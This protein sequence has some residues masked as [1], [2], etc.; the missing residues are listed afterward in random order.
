MDTL[1]SGCGGKKGGCNLPADRLMNIYRIFLMMFL[2]QK[3]K[4]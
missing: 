2:I 3:I 1:Q 4:R